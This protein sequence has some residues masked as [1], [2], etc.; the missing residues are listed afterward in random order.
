M[1]TR[2]S[3]CERRAISK[4]PRQNYNGLFYYVWA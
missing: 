4:I 3:A 2:Q 1:S